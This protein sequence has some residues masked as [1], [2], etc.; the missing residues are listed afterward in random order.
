MT[1]LVAIADDHP[2][3]LAGLEHI[4]SRHR[5]LKL[6]GEASNSTELIALLQRQA[7]DVVV[8]DY[9]MPGGQYG[10]GITLLSLLRRRFPR[11][12]V[13]VLTG[14][15]HANTF[16]HL[17]GL[18]VD[19]LVSKT[20]DFALLPTAIAQAHGGKRFLSEKI[21]ALLAATGT[22]E[23]GD[24]S[25]VRLTK[26]ESEVLRMFAEGLSVTEIADRIGRSRKTVSTQKTSVMKKLSLSSNAE[27]CRYAIRHGLIQASGATQTDDVTP[28]GNAA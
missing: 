28:T 22:Q 11:V 13:V 7:V 20:D 16:Q 25:D 24:A 6:V 1:I 14:L 21:N 23:Q 9:A 8:T 3:L 27:L 10:D 15:E 4:V 17:L 2:A 19:A 26:R 18:G 12:R 5:D